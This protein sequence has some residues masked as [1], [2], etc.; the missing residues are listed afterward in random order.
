MNAMLLLAIELSPTMRMVAAIGTL[1]ATILLPTMVVGPWIASR[2][3]MRDHSGRISFLLLCITAAIVVIGLSSGPKYGVDLKGGVI[4]VYDANL[5]PEAEPGVG[6]EDDPE[7]PPKVS[8]S[9][10]AAALGPR[11]NPGGNKE[12][13]I[14]PY[15]ESQIEIIIPEVDNREIEEIKRQVRNAGILLFRIVAN[16]TDHQA[17][18]QA[19]EVQADHRLESVRKRADV[20][21]AEGTKIGQWVDAGRDDKFVPNTKLKKLKSDWTRFTLRD[22]STGRLLRRS[23][24][25]GKTVE[26][27]GKEE[28]V[29]F[30][31]KKPIFEKWLEEEGIDD[32]EVLVVEPSRPEFDVQG[33]D[34]GMVAKDYDEMTNLCVSFSLNSAGAARMGTLTSSNLPD[35]DGVT[36][37]QLGIVL[38]GKLLSAPNIQSTITNR[39]RITGRFTPEEIDFLINILRA[40]RLPAALDPEP[41]TENIIGPTLGQDT[42]EK[43]AKSIAISLAAVLVFIA[44]Y[45]RFAG[46]VACFVLLLNILFTFALIILISAPLTLPGLAGLVLTVGMSVD[47]N[48]LIFERIREELVKGAK[49]RLAVRHGFERASRTIIDANV[50]TLITAIVLYAIGTDQVRGFATMLILGILMCMFTAIF[51]ARLIFDVVIHRNWIS[52]LK[53][54]SLLPKTD[55][56]FLGKRIPAAAISV[57]LIVVGLFAVYSRGMEIFD[58]DFNGGTSVTVASVDKLSADDVRDKLNTTSEQMFEDKVDITVTS[59]QIDSMADK[60]VWQITTSLREEKQIKKLVKDSLKVESYTME[61]VGSFASDEGDGSGNTGG[62]ATGEGECQ[63]DD[64]DSTAGADSQLGD[65]SLTTVLLKFNRKIESTALEGN[66]ATAAETLDLGSPSVGV[67]T[68]AGIDEEDHDGMEW[69]VTIGLSQANADRLVDQVMEQLD[70]QPIWI[71][72]STIGGKVAGKTRNTAIA[73]LLASLVGIVIYIWIRFQKVVFGLAAVVALV[74]DVLIT[75]GAIAVSA[76]LAGALGFLLIDEF[77]ISLPVVAAFLTII[78]YSLND[79]IVV[80]D[81]IREVRGKSPD[82]TFEMVNTSINQTLSRTILT[83]L[84]TLLV[85]L[86]LYSIGGQGIH[87]FAFALIVGV[88]VGTYSSIFVASPALLTMMDYVTKRQ[89]AAKQAKTAK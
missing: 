2:L 57:V 87:G 20:R 28:P 6:E 33:D 5:Q 81:R 56:D 75:L 45:Y 65:E 69:S 89:M 63:D 34:L 41:A 19:A 10:L 68:P 1:L 32:L 70:G 23:D 80:F 14:R 59:V 85:V 79:T 24:Y 40:G 31:E 61:K 37:R 7:A 25:E 58:I 49:L 62:D 77:R 12:I 11:V 26:Y 15:G 29:A 48:V 16:A 55:V 39:G 83:S 71:S 53:L 86:I 43:G 74:H 73:A 27:R 44:A 66:F 78:G 42:I 72:A 38:D 3:R 4:L 17:L 18:I 22:G 46:L 47:A 50:T 8:I 60:N 21:S 30:D 67:D 13:V 36:E 9:D 82:L 64:A 54:R 52:E 88:L 76:W 84:T 35:Q 51:C